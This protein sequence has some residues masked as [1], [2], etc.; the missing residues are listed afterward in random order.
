MGTII[1]A[2]AIATADDRSR[3]PSAV[4]LAD[5]AARVCLERAGRGPDDVQLLIS[6]GVYLDRNISEPAIASLIQEDI[7]AHLEIDPDRGQGTLSFDV[8]NGACGFLTGVY[9]VDALLASSTVER[10]MVVG[11]DADPDPGL[12]EGFPFPAA[13]GA[14]LLSSDDS[15]PGLTAFKFKTFPEFADDFQSY[16]AWHE[17]LGTGEGRNTLTIEVGGQYPAHA[18]DCADATVRELA[19]E[20]GVDLADVDLVMAT[21][22]APGFAGALAQRLGIAS[23]R[24]A[25]SSDDLASAHTAAP[26]IAL[27]SAQLAASR[28]ALLL[29][30]GA[31]ITVVAA[32]YRA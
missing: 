1:E 27:E 30:A 3:P 9:L 5:A 20:E 31:G 16:I 18:L 10:G 14:V 22:S 23:A 6:A 25:S 13:G 17:S 7:G 11:G 4:E 2:T 26:A 8:R 15:R 12:S 29:S 19:V 32:I 24:I 28:T 21:A